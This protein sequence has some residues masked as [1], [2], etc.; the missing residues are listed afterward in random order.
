MEVYRITLKKWA[1]SLKASGFAGRWNSKGVFVIYTS[2][3]RALTSLENLVHRSG[4]GLHKSFKTMVIEIP[5]HLKIREVKPGQ[6]SKNWFKYEKY[7]EC[8]KIGD[9]WIEESK[10]PILKVPSAIIKL[11]NNY[12]LNPNHEQF[13]QIKIATVED[14]RFDP[15]LKE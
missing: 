11:E 4:E 14:F 12:L 3:T 5:K 1:K 8:Q 13:N 7:S 15:R 9:A 2:K 6:L 10:Y